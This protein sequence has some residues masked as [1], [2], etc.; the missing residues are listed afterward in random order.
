MLLDDTD[1]NQL[2]TEQHEDVI[3]TEKNESRAE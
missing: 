3:Y 1:Q 2:I